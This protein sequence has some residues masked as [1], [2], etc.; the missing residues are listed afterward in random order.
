MFIFVE[1]NQGILFLWM[2]VIVPRIAAVSY[3]DTTPF[4]YGIKHEGNLRAELLLSD[5]TTTVSDFNSGRADLALVPVHVV[6]TLRQAR[7]VTDYCIGYR[8]NDEDD[9]YLPIVD[10]HSPI[11]HL[12]D[13]DH[14][15]LSRLLDLDEPWAYAVWVAHIDTDPNLVEHLQHALTFGLERLYESLLDAGVPD[16]VESYDHLM[17]LDFG[18]DEQKHETLKK[19]WESGFKVPLHANPG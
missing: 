16:P 8:G 19:F 7:I 2:M 13:G 1:S 11:L 4:L 15:P 18:L 6:P 10:P 17:H 14:A 5:F 3:L 9:E 12:F